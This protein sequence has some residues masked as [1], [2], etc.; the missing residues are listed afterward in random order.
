MRNIYMLQ[1]CDTHGSGKN[2]SA[3]LPYATGLL[4]AYA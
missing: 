2:E 3:Y 4:I 1:P